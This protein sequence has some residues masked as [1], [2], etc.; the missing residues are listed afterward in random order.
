MASVAAG[1]LGLRQPG[2]LVHLYMLQ[3]GKYRDVAAEWRLT[4]PTLPMGMN[5]GDL[6]NDGYLDFYIGTGYPSYE[7]LMPNLM[8]RNQ[9]GKAFADVTTAGGFGHLQKG[10]AV[11][12]AD[13]D[14]D[15]DQ[16]IYQQMGGA[17]PGD[18][19]GNALF[20]NPGFDRHWIKIRL[21]GTRSNRSAIGARL[22]LDLTDAGRRRSIYRTVNGG[23]FGSSPL[24]QEIGLGRAEKVD[25]IEVHWPA[26]GLTQRFENVGVD[27]L[28][29]IVEDRSEYRELELKR[30]AFA[31]ER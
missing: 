17:Y 10:H 16:D 23:S 3:D 28:I 21:V 22:R 14:N 24:R 7:G 26:S 30:I 4:R 11:V 31:V 5:F 20:E 8:Y 15:G 2:E 13:L 12:F 9:Q 27:Q 29:E 25:R 18:A 1:Y 6:D 19:F